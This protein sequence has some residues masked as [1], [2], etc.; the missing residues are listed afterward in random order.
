MLVLIYYEG[1]WLEIISPYI[2]L[3]QASN[4]DYSTYNP[5]ICN[6]MLWLTELSPSVN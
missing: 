2:L 1:I 5:E 6:Q 3:I 4:I